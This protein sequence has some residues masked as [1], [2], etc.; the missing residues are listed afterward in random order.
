MKKIVSILSLAAMLLGFTTIASP[1]F[2]QSVPPAP[3]LAPTPLQ[4][5]Q[6][7]IYPWPIWHDATSDAV[8][9]D[10]LPSSGRMFVLYYRN[11]DVLSAKQ[12][13]RVQDA[14]YRQPWKDIV[15]YYKVDAAGDTDK[16]SRTATEPVMIMVVPDAGGKLIVLNAAV[17]YRSQAETYDFFVE[18]M[19]NPPVVKQ[20]SVV[21]KANASDV[22]YEIER[23]KRP[24]AVLY[25]HSDSFLGLV[26]EQIFEQ[27]SRA[28][29]Q[30]MSF[31][32]IDV[33]QDEQGT[34]SLG[35]TPSVVVYQDNGQGEVIAT[36]SAVGFQD[37]AG[38]ESVLP[39]PVVAPT[40][41]P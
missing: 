38:I 14:S 30:E 18:S 41:T 31:M 13:M 40:T 39:K 35:G 15:R 17:G 3:L 8:L 6:T 1:A 33:I 37:R 29:S 4:P 22:A 11:G 23:S 2:G 32:K 21:I 34:T 16:S 10:A 5:S 24:V 19:K 36:S 28:H 25:Y 12:E 7:S 27:V 9:Q 20:P 26:E